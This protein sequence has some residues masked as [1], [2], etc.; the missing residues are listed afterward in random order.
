MS[1][2]ATGPHICAQTRFRFKISDFTGCTANVALITPD[3]YYI[4]NCG[5]S[6]SVLCR[7]GKSLFLSFDHKPENGTELERIVR[8]GGRVEK[9]RI[10]NGLN[11]SRSFGDYFYKSNA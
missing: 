5:D 2:T 3:E 10:N 1:K 7:K 6:R 4:A 8:A 11:L 9:G